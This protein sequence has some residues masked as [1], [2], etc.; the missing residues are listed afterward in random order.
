[1]N[2]KTVL[3]IDVGYGN[4]KVVWGNDREGCEMHF[5]SLAPITMQDE[6]VLAGIAGSM[7]RTTV[8]V[9]GKRYLVGPEAYLAGGV[10]ILEGN[11]VKH[12]EYLAL[13]RGA[14]HY[15]M[16]R[17]GVIRQRIDALAVGLPVSNFAAH[18]D[19]LVQLVK[20]I[21]LIPTPAGLRSVYGPTVEVV[22]DKVLVLPQPIGALRA[23]AQDQYNLDSINNAKATNLIVDPG[24]NTFDWLMANGM[25]A[26]LER[27]G[28]F[29]G[30]VAHIL[31]EV[32]GQAGKVLGVG[33]I[34]LIECEE[35]LNSGTLV[36]GAKRYDFERFS[37][38]A[39]SAA[40]TVVNTFLNSLNTTRRFDK[41]IMTGGGA[42]YYVKAL[43][44]RFPDYE[45]L[46]ERDSIMTNARGFYLYAA[47]LVQ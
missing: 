42:R 1:V 18:K 20:G 28:S 7:D 23:H 46:V 12:D 29:P 37:Q 3:A 21:H 16:R 41:I 11:F 24:Y 6:N 19:A 40:A 45:I 2:K 38:I 44:D 34:D 5:R 30:G 36:I 26:D 8:E 32:S 47:G 25:R 17:S 10:P 35:A 14:M 39:E 43:Q 31:R 27:S 33:S 13:V 9:K 4:T 22:V 15:M